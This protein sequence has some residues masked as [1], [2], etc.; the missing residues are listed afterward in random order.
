MCDFE[1]G[2]GNIRNIA[3]WFLVLVFILIVLLPTFLELGKTIMCSGH[4]GRLGA[5]SLFCPTQRHRMF[6]LQ[7]KFCISPS[8]LGNLEVAENAAM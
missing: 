5:S 2:F 6:F 3:F 8:V 4:A 1:C 7:K